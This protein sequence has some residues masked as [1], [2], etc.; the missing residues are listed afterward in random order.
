MIIEAGGTRLI[1]QL[2]PNQN[3]FPF[4]VKKYLVVI[5]TTAYVKMMFTPCKEH[6][7]MPRSHFYANMSRKSH[8]RRLSGK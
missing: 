6:S 4:S 1:A 7:T 5:A 8:A 2:I 3:I